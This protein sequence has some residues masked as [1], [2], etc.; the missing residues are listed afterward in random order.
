MLERKILVQ[1]LFGK[2]IHFAGA[3][4]DS[5][6]VTAPLKEFGCDRLYLVSQLPS[7]QREFWRASLMNDLFESMESEI[8]TINI[9]CES[10]LIAIFRAIDEVVTQELA[11]GNNLYINVSSGSRLFTAAAAMVGSH[12]TVEL[13]YVQRSNYTVQREYTTGIEK[14]VLLP[15]IQPKASEIN[16]DSTLCFMV[17]PFE[18]KIQAIYEDIVKPLIVNIG[19]RCLR[20]DDFFDNRPVMDDIWNG[21][22]KA[23][24]VIADLTGRNANVFYETGIAHAMGKEVIL[25]TQ[26]LDDVPFDLRHLRCLV[27]SDNIRGGK[28]LRDDLQRTLQTVLTRTK[29]PK[30]K[31][32]KS[33]RSE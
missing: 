20:A 28:K 16:I 13:Y 18:E 9:K 6:V 30:A 7:L 8:E 17:M 10:N 12:R 31:P 11:A 23:R 32:V 4:F 2:N 24:V 14:V 15:H 29:L 26:R 25:L 22:E 1:N 27:Y 3:G 19:L 21:I 33:S 5:A